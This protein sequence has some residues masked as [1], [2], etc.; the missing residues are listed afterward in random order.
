MMKRHWT[1]KLPDQVPSAVGNQFAAMIPTAIIMTVTLITFIVFDKVFNSTFLDSIYAVIQAPLQGI[2]DSPFAILIIGFLVPFFWF[3]GVHGGLIVGSLAGSFLGANALDNATAYANHH[4]AWNLSV[5]GVHIVTSSMYDN[6]INLT[7]S[8]IT[9][10]LIVFTLFFAK[11]E[12]MRSIG[13]I[14]S[15]PGIFN[16]NEPFMFGLPII[17]N[18]LL[19]IPFFLTPTLAVGLS[20][21]AVY[22]G[23]VPPLTGIQAS[24]TVPAIISGFLIGG[25]Q[26]SVLQAVVLLLSTA[27]YFPF[28]KK[29]DMVLLKQEQEKLAQE[30]AE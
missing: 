28:A 14:E 2:S 1:I 30:T 29:F 15:V 17:L 5:P 19:A 23:I 16:I 24:W 8:G 6:I 18:P 11:S 22:F 25:W 12:Q 13:K 9:M 7:G 21:G 20:Y 10:G 27:L 26:W 4:G 3:F